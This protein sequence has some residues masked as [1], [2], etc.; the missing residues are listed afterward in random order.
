[1]TAPI[2]GR[3][4]RA[5]VT[6]GNLVSSGPGEAT[7][8]TTRGVDRSDL[9]A[10][11]RRR[12]DIFLQYAAWRAGPP[13]Q[14]RAPTLPIALALAGDDDFPRE[15]QLDFLDNQLDPAPAPSAARAIF[16]NPDGDLTPGLFVRLRLPGSG[17]LRAAC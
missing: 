7:L 2:D 14:R 10:L 13:R 6:E 8:L 5:I 9:R 1:M 11:R 3:V 17:R 15:G 12:A 4:G 16:R